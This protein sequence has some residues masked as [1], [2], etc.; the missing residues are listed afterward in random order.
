MIRATSDLYIMPGTLSGPSHR[1]ECNVDYAADSWYSWSANSRWI[2]FASKREGGVYAYLYLT[3]ISE[4]GHASPAIPLPIEEKPSISFNI[5]EFIHNRPAIPENEL[6]DALRVEQEP[7]TV[8]LR[9]S[10]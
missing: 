8:Q 4:D 7:V 1:L 6:F 5:P 10:H 3:H 9:K 2:V